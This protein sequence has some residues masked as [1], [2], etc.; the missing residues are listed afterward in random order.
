MYELRAATP[1]DYEFL[2]DLLVATMKEY[3]RQIWGWEETEQRERFRTRFA[4]EKF[5][6]VV[7]EGQNVGAVSVERRPTELF[8]SEI[9]IQPAFQRRRLGTAIIQDLIHEAGR[10]ALP[11]GLQVLKINPARGLYDRLGFA[12]TGETDTHYLMSRPV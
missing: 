10:Q 3:V 8:L 11:V 12:V 7:V 6:I 1:D 9:Q 4:P 5:E 2:Y